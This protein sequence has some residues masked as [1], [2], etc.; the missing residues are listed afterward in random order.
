MNNNPN[1][2]PQTIEIV[3]KPLGNRMVVRIEEETN[4]VP[5]S[6]LILPDVAQ[7]KPCRGTIISVGPGNVHNSTGKR[8]PLT[9]KPGQ[10]IVYNRTSGT[11]IKFLDESLLILKEGDILGYLD[12]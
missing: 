3:I 12:E 10:R 7:I 6:N 1:L 2:N 8:V 11:V 5:G 9:A 4:E